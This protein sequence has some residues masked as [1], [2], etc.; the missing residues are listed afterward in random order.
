MLTF[1]QSQYLKTIIIACSLF[2]TSNSFAEDRGIDISGFARLVGGSVSDNTVRGNGYDNKWRFDKESLLAVQATGRLSDKV[3]ATGQLLY[4]ASDERD[5]GIEWAYLTYHYNQKLNFKVGKLRTPFSQYS[6]VIDVGF[7]YPWITPPKQVYNDYMF[8]T[9]EGANVSYNYVGEQLAYYFEGY[10]GQFDDELYI[11]GFRT[12]TKV[13]DLKGL[14]VNVAKDNLSFRL[15][16]HN[17]YVEIENDVINDFAFNLVQLGF[18]ESAQSLNTYGHVKS[19]QTSLSYDSLN[20]FTRVELMRISSDIQYV[21]SITAGYA[22]LGYYFNSFTTHITYAKNNSESASPSNE[23]SI[24]LSPQLDQLA[25][26]YQEIFNS[27]IDINKESIT[28]GVKWD[29]KTNMAIKFDFSIIDSELPTSNQSDIARSNSE[30][31]NLM[32][33]GLEWVF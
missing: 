28:L 23:I 7:S 31:V 8:S 12:S 27:Q 20:Y 29:C 1:K 18:N 14:V 21:P 2:S 33:V 32:Q 26:G 25:Y 10:W 22:T 30:Q 9:F 15:S 16:Y 11:N 13:D 24:G 6:D 19:I 5:S 4:H 17:G 3:S